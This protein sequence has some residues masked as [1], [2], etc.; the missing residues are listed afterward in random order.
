VKKLLQSVAWL[1]GAALLILVL[2]C[3]IA[4]AALAPQPGEWSVSLSLWRWQREASVPTLLRWVTHPLVLAHLNG[5]AF[6]TRSARWRLQVRADGVLQAHCAPCRWQV[7]ALGP[8]PVTI[9]QATFTLRPHGADAFDGELELGSAAQPVRLPWRG[10][11]KADGMH[12]HAELA[13]TPVARV[14]ALF[15]DAVP[16][17]ARAQ[18]D[19]SV[20]LRIDATLGDDG[21]QF[22]RLVPTLADVSVQGLGTEA[23]IDADT[24]ARCRPQPSGGRVEGWIQ[25]AVIA[26]EDRRFFEHPGYELDAW[27][28]VGKGNQQQ[29]E[30]LQGASTITQQLAKLLYTGDERDPA[31]KL[32]EWLYAVEMERTL[33]KGRI[34]QLYLAVLPWGDGICGAEAAA[35]HHL[36][37][38][39]NQLKPREAA[40][41]A[42]LLINPDLQL[43][44]WAADDAQA[45][46][47]AAF[48]LKGMKR[49]PRERRDAELE[50]LATWQP[51]VARPLLAPPTAAV[52]HASR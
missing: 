22:Q 39:A 44:R 26:A 28:A 16:E 12:W 40:W 48:V 9:G 13:P 51:P 37:K 33:G 34:L 24:G 27:V 50:A 41:L 49:L 18:V 5:Q 2:L 32:R 30:A 19:G 21:V 1:M 52:R 45:R 7:A 31:R 42:S 46:E 15:G 4:L 10:E 6:T 35:R 38:P 23:L 8:R 25:N 17:M 3:A 43:R 47:R 14:V 36:G 29:P 11:L 20:A